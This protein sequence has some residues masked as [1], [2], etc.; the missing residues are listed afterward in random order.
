MTSDLKVYFNAVFAKDSNSD[1]FLV[2]KGVS[3]QQREL[4]SWNI[5]E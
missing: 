3:T 2:R 1:T 5:A 4:H